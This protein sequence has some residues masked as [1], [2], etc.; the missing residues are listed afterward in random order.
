M[1]AHTVTPTSSTLHAANYFCLRTKGSNNMSA[2]RNTKLRLE[3][4]NARI[5]VLTWY[6]ANGNDLKLA[7]EQA[8]KDAGAS[9]AAVKF[10]TFTAARKHLKSIPRE[11][12]EKYDKDILAESHTARASLEHQRKALR[13][14]ERPTELH[15][16]RKSRKGA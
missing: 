6:R 5:V 7:R 11:T 12:R 2:R 1:Y 8:K 15:K 13:S 9:T 3:H 14:T 4:L 16:E 10:A